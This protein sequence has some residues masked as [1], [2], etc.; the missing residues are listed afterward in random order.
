MSTLPRYFLLEVLRPLLAWLGLL[1]VVLM[2][3][4]FLRG[5]EVLLG[6]TI[7]ALDL[8]RFAIWLTPHFFVQAAPIAFLLALLLG[9][10]RLADDGEPRAA[11]LTP[12]A[13]RKA[14]T[15]A[16]WRGPFTQSPLMVPGPRLL[17]VTWMV[18]V[19][20]LPMASSAVAEIATDPSGSWVVSD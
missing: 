17:T 13:Y 12:P 7:T 5:I 8:A 2:V 6:S 10:G 3:M 14:F 15:E 11:P 20:E 1:W 9:M 16:P 18:T 19:I 4:A